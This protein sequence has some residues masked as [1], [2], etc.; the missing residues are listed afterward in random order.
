MNEFSEKLIKDLK[1]RGWVTQPKKKFV[2]KVRPNEL[3]SQIEE[4]FLEFTEA[5]EPEP[6]P[7]PTPTPEPTP[8]PVP[9][10][11]DPVIE[12]WRE[13]MEVF[14]LKYALAMRD[15]AISDNDKL[16]AYYYDAAR[17]FL[18]I[19]AETQ[20]DVFLQAATEA[21]RVYIDYLKSA[22]TSEGW[23][24]V[25]GYWNF[26]HGL[27]MFAERGDI[28]AREACINLSRN[29]AFSRDLTND[30]ADNTASFKCS[31]EVA[32]AINA[33]L[34]AME[35]GE[36]ERPRLRKLIDFA[37]GH[38]D[39]W[40]VSRTAEW[41]QPFMVGLTCEAL[42]A[43]YEWGLH[44][45][46]GIHTAIGRCVAGLAGPFEIDGVTKPYFD[47]ATGKFWYST[48]HTHPGQ[49]EDQHYLTADLNLLICPFFKWYNT[50]AM[51]TLA[52]EIFT[53]GVNGAWLGN[54]KQFNQN[55]RWSFEYVKGRGL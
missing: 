25:P 55:Y 14:G 31:R 42:I 13:N 51:N 44:K 47:V 4:S 46:G 41:C 7:E 49:P 9:T 34:C 36:P 35:L 21:K 1:A 12:K 37:L 17:V 39:Q 10:P 23:G 3:R 15:P 32:Y 43:A 28:E 45:R 26:P 20:S 19:H 11:I 24:G 16:A 5:P 53:G 52:S 38:V 18:Q 40:F 33:H 8:V 50:V 2:I 30:V 6:I 48:V 22:T 27:Q 29:A 54:A